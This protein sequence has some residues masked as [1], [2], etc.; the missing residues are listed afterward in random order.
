[1]YKKK[2]ENNEN[3]KKIISDLIR[4]LFDHA[5][6]L[7]GPR[8]L[9]LYEAIYFYDF[10]MMSRRTIPSF[11]KDLLTPIIN[12]TDYHGTLSNLILNSTEEIKIIDLYNDFK[13]TVKDLDS[14]RST[15][16]NDEQAFRKK[17][18]TNKRFRR[19]TRINDATV[20]PTINTSAS[21]SKDDGMLRT[22][23]RDLL[24][25]IELQ[26]LIKTDRT[27]SGEGLIRRVIWF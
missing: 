2:L 12:P 18:E 23:F 8:T 20:T 13:Q 4:S 24:Y 15:K 9:P 16:V 21:D 11:R 6:L 3:C 5:D 25:S 1:M 7:K 22:V 14:S 10:D 19:S 26:G 27:R 17:S